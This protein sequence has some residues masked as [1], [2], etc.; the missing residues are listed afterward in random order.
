MPYKDSL[1]VQ[2]ADI[3]TAIGCTYTAMGNKT[4]GLNYCE[5]ALKV[6]KSLPR[7]KYNEHYLAVAMMEKAEA[8]SLS[9]KYHEAI[10]SLSKVEKILQ[11]LGHES[12]EMI[13]LLL[14]KGLAYVHIQDYSNSLLCFKKALAISQ[15]LY[16]EDDKFTLMCKDDIAEVYV[17]MNNPLQSL[18]YSNEVYKVL[19][20]KLQKQDD[21]ST[22]FYIN[23]LYDILD[24][25]GFAYIKLS[26]YEDAI[27][28]Y[29]EA[30]NIRYRF[31]INDDLYIIENLFHAAES[32]KEI[33][34]TKYIELARRAYTIYRTLPK[35]PGCDNQ[36]KEWEKEFGVE[37]LQASRKPIVKYGNFDP[38][39]L[40]VKFL[41]QSNILTPI[42]EASANG[43]WNDESFVFGNRGV[44][45][46]LDDECLKGHLGKLSQDLQNIEK[47]KMLIFEAIALGVMNISK[48]KDTTCIKEFARENPELVKR[49]AKEHPEYFIDHYII[50]ELSKELPELGMWLSE[51]TVN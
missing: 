21:I 29:E 24:K 20:D 27:K 19:S 38:E 16:K 14:L 50:Q 48:T 5:K 33:D 46:Y 7:S 25:M 51:E 13:R 8:H 22:Q 11:R 40:K 1:N 6:I 42:Q 17:K 36:I 2:T 31:N 49:I 37:S 34:R 9:G 41:I 3:F 18:E 47:A 23:L 44:K 35:E 26:K 4:E 10:D 32:Y 28:C 15:K 43:S 12:K 30:L 39:I 45:G